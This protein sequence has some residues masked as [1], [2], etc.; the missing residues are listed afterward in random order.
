[1]TLT[2][3]RFTL[4]AVLT[5]MASAYMPPPAYALEPQEIPDFQ[6]MAISANGRYVVS[7]LY[8]TVQIYDTEND[9]YVTF[10][11]NEETESHS[12]GMGRPIT[13]DGS[14]IVGESTDCGGA[15]YLTS[16]KWHSLKTPNPNLS[17][18]VNG[19][20]PDG[21]RICGSLGMSVMTTEDTET[22]ML[23]PG[24]WQRNADG[25]YSDAILLPH[26]QYDFTGRVPQYITANCISDD[27]KTIVGQIRDY[28]GFIQ[29]LIVYS[30]SED[31]VWS[32]RIVG[33]DLANPKNMTFP[34]WP[35]DGPAEPSAET[36]LSEDE[37]AEYL[38]A[39]NAWYAEGA[40]AGTWNYNTEPTPEE[41]LSDAERAEYEAAYIAWVTEY[42]AWVEKYNA[43][44]LL[45]IECIEDGHSLVFNNLYMTGDGKTVVSGTAESFEDPD[46]YTG[47]SDRY[48]PVVFNLSDDSYK[49][50]STDANALP[51]WITDDGTIFASVSTSITPARSVAYLPGSETPITLLEYMKAHDSA[52]AEWMEENMFHDVELVNQETMETTTLE[53]CDCT[54]IA[55]SNVSGSL[56]VTRSENYWDMYTNSYIFSYLLPDSSKSGIKSVAADTYPENVIYNLQGVRL[57]GNIETLPKGLYIINGKKIAK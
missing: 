56:I 29:Q 44:T 16:G 36:Y 15:G 23:L 32:Y 24:Y 7:D 53:N 43:F 10:Y 37:K 42:N 33:K 27:G 28:S 41:Y 48:A 50:Y 21:E 19:I 3:S 49:I 1:M 22:P 57:I 17:N 54:G 25:S 12:I 31:G 55:R 18:L 38:A 6:G 20:T 2:S 5:V 9:R 47:L 39:Y 14:I 30:E 40:A 11:G 26:P 51:S 13:A 35:G 46:S 45:L 52:T 4:T 8:G 34:E